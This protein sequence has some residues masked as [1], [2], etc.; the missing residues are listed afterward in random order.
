MTGDPPDGRK[1]DDLQTLWKA[2]PTEHAPMSLADI[3]QAALTFERKVRRRNL[4]EYVATALV[5]L[6]FMSVLF[7]SASWMMQA[8]AALVIVAALWVARHMHKTASARAAPE[9]DAAIFDFHRQELIRQRDA[10]RS[11]GRW[12]LGPFVP[13]MVLMMAGRWFQ[14][15]APGRS[16]EVDHLFILAG[17]AIVVLIFTGVWALNQWGARRLQQRID[18]L[19]R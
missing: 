5:V 2:Q 18:D 9:A 8:G 10:L 6:A 3:H 12:Y 17:S 7:K 4:I 13:G 19:D 15:H 14:A 1:P 16:V 11:V